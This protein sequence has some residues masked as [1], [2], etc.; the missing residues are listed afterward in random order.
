MTTNILL[1]LL[2]GLALCMFIAVLYLV[3]VA[4]HWRGKYAKE[5]RQWSF[6]YEDAREDAQM[7]H[8]KYN[9]EIAAVITDVDEGEDYV[10]ASLGLPSDDELEIRAIHQVIRDHIECDCETDDRL[11][12]LAERI[13][14]A[15]N[16][17]H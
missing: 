12:H 3:G 14:T 8:R 7:W 2:A 11:E 10:R 16:E 6:R 5:S 1:G 15:L 13:S 9:D 17:R 4:S